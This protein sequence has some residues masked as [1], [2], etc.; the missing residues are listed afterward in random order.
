LKLDIDAR[1]YP[2]AHL[3]A[4]DYAVKNFLSKWKGLLT[5]ID[6]EKVALDGWSAAELVCAETNGRI[7]EFLRDGAKGKTFVNRP[8][9]A[10]IS[11][12]QSKIEK[13]LG[14]APNLAALHKG[15][16]WSGGAT[17]D[18]K[19]G[20]PI[21]KKMTGRISCTESALPYPRMEIESDPQ[22]VEALTGVYPSGPLSL[23]KQ[24]FKIVKGNRFL[25]VPKNAKTDRCI[26]A[27]P[28]GNSFLQQGVGRYIRKRL[29]RFGVNLDDQSWNQL[30]ARKAE[31]IGLATL[32][33]SAASD[34]I[35]TD[36][37]F[38]LL[39]IEWA[40]HLDRLRSRYSRVRGEWVYLSKFSSMGNAFTFE[41]ESLIFWS[42]VEACLEDGGECITGVYGDDIVVPAS[43]APR[44]IEVLGWCG[45][46]LNKEKSFTSGPFYESCG[47]HY[48]HG[49]EVTPVY[50]K[51]FIDSPDGGNGNFI[52]EI[53]RLHNR[54]VRWSIRYVGLV[55]SLGFRAKL[56][57]IVDD[58]LKKSKIY[59][60][61]KIPI[62][63]VSDDGLLVDVRELDWDC[64]HGF[65]CRVY[66]FQPGLRRVWNSPLYAY[67]LR[68]PKYL[69]VDPKGYGATANGG[70]WIY[71]NRYI[72]SAYEVSSLS[73]E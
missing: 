64:N 41:L 46:S 20:S 42:I 62:D 40:L 70:E 43:V 23:L 44:V 10:I 19:R 26:A 73:N 29:R 47:K 37:I 36:L 2:N 6:T 50:Q 57:R 14:P 18:L 55:D 54:M 53:V 30:L 59:D 72:H 56:R 68:R 38:L 51:K 61:P 69:N 65:Y 25:T 32:D 31:K 9:E 34:T 15:C 5:G 45:F 21:S 28:S 58:A 12:A 3:F 60:C 4:G 17:F 39:P 71:R 8:V 33:L 48:F 35:S 24:N 1:C 49:Y 67:K 27:E 13:V 7:R 22:W 52:S 66:V 16:K 11:I 63:D